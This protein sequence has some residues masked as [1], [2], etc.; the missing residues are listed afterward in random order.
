MVRIGC[1]AKEILYSRQNHN[2]ATN[3]ETANL[4]QGCLTFKRCTCL[5]KTCLQFPVTDWWLTY[6]IGLEGLCCL[7]LMIYLANCVAYMSRITFKPIEP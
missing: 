4:R 6:M 2:L 1:C 7:F 3:K 5:V